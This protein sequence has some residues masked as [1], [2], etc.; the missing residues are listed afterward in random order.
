MPPKMKIGRHNYDYS[1]SFSIS[2]KTTHAIQENDLEE[3]H[4][5]HPPVADTR[6]GLV[7]N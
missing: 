6:V 7:A 1:K 4:P 3:P 2:S 5:K